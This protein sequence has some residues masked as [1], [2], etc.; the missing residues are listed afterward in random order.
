MRRE[1]GEKFVGREGLH[2]YEFQSKFGE[3]AY[4]RGALY[5]LNEVSATDFVE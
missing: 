2:C 3:C 4:S 5:E 1:N